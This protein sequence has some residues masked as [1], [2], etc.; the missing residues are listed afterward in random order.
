MKDNL[1]IEQKIVLVNGNCELP[2]LGLNEED[3]NMLINNV[4]CVFHCAATVRFDEHIRT[5]AYTN[6]R[7]T[8]DLISLAKKMKNLKVHK[9]FNRFNK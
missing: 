3:V 4:D 1:K 8:Q 9:L 6:V 7:S 2:N 5:A